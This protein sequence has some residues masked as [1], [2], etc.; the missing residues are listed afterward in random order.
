VEELNPRRNSATFHQDIQ[1]QPELES[2][3]DVLENVWPETALADATSMQLCVFVRDGARVMDRVFKE[4]DRMLL[5]FKQE[6]EAQQIKIWELESVVDD[7]VLAWL[8]KITTNMNEIVSTIVDNCVASFKT[9]AMLSDTLADNKHIQHAVTVQFDASLTHLA[10]RLQKRDALVMQTSDCL[11]HYG[12]LFN[13]IEDHLPRVSQ[14]AKA[15]GTSM[16]TNLANVLKKKGS[17][18]RS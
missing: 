14:L 7:S 12:K 2:F 10:K 18:E 5:E 4:F 6:K 15:A 13:K 9:F 16:A 8:Q 17:I 3:Q 1:T 11:K